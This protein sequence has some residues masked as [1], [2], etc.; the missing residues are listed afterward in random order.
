M[1]QKLPANQYTK[2]EP[3]LSDT[4]RHHLFCLGVLNGRYDGMI[5]VDDVQAPQT[6]VIVKGKTWCY[7]AGNP[8]NNTFTQALQAELA[9]RQFFDPQST[10]LLLSL[11]SDAWLPLFNTLLPT[12]KPVEMPRHLFI[13]KQGQTRETVT[14]P[15]EIT[16]HFIDETL[17][18]EGELPSDVNEVLQL[19]AKA[20]S[21]DE[22][23]FG[24]VALHQGK[25]VAHAMID[26]IVGTDGE[27]GLYTNPDF[28]RKGL[29]MAVSKATI[30]YGLAHGLTTVHWDCA[31][32]NHGSNV[33]AQKLGLQK[34]LSHNMYL[35]IF[36]EG[37]HW[38][39]VA[40]GHLDNGRY[41]QLLTAC[42]QLIQKEQY[43]SHAYFLLGVAYLN[44]GDEGKAWAALQTT[45]QE[46]GW[47]DLGE[48]NAHYQLLQKETEKWSDIVS[49]IQTN[50]S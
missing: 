21:P 12:H 28:R 43:L 42:Q 40:W 3:L 49:H 44:L 50:H 20:D 6:A 22:V 23:A 47:N 26:C 10:S 2:I 27:I 13:G 36:E 19:R 32:F 25:C 1:L 11:P 4:T 30:D 39:N 33:I 18:V 24:Y 48:L 9:D 7:F 5:L 38:A 41:P 35:L 37:L 14:L 34:T 46:Y 15:D 29:A 8:H 31:T 17:Q 16:L 45:V